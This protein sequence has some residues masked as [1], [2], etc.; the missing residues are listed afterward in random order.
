[1]RSPLELML[2]LIAHIG[3]AHAEAQ[4]VTASATMLVRTTVRI[5][6]FSRS[7]APP[8]GGKRPAALRPRNGDSASWQRQRNAPRCRRLLVAETPV[9]DLLLCAKHL[10]VAATVGCAGE[11]SAVVYL[12]NVCVG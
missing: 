7:F 10:F 4:H 5:P 2:P 11:D 12:T 1:M 6:G 9:R 3:C 8:K